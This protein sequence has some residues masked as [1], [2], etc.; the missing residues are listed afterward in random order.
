MNK[1]NFKCRIEAE[2]ENDFDDLRNKATL[3]ANLKMI[4]YKFIDG[5][6]KS[7]HQIGFSDGQNIEE[8]M[9]MFDDFIKQYNPPETPLIDSPADDIALFMALESS[10]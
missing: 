9:E 10:Q 8:L 6:W 2:L 4:I 5:K 7:I 1:T 3:S